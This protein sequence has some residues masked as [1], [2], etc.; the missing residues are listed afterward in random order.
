MNILLKTTLALALTTLVLNAECKIFTS[1][2][3]NFSELKGSD[4]VSLS[5]S[6]IYYKK[7]KNGK[8]KM[9]F[10]L[11]QKAFLEFDEKAREY[12][13][14][15]CAKNNLSTIYNYQIRTVGSKDWYNFY[16]TYDYK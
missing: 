9:E 16:A 8:K 12:I 3:T 6:N 2:A 10:K 5:I 14:G 11:A 13:Q 1:P 7:G 4:G 15:M